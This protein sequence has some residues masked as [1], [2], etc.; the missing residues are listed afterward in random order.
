MNCDV[1]GESTTNIGQGKFRREPANDPEPSGEQLPLIISTTEGLREIGEGIYVKDYTI[2]KPPVKGGGA[3][4]ENDVPAN[5]IRTVEKPDDD[6]AVTQTLSSTHTLICMSPMNENVVVSLDDAEVKEEFCSD[7]LIDPARWPEHIV[8]LVD[9]GMMR[10]PLDI[11]KEALTATADVLRIPESIIISDT[12]NN[13]PNSGS[14]PTF[15]PV[16]VAEANTTSPTVSNPALQRSLLIK[17]KPMPPAD[18]EKRAQLQA[19]LL[20]SHLATDIGSSRLSRAQPP[21]THSKIQ[22]HLPRQET[23]KASLGG[24]S[25]EGCST[26]EPQTWQE[27]FVG[28]LDAQKEE[29][30]D[31]F[32]ELQAAYAEAKATISV[33]VDN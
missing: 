1:S 29:D 2:P 3:S 8:D 9:D 15:E 33:L 5:P 17:R 6:E 19:Q 4:R 14:L 30:F 31:P 20:R 22:C 32:R 28:S 24:N 21:D 11:V 26:I 10:G 13:S 25:M 7:Y 16:V 12:N 23:H 27:G 18:Q